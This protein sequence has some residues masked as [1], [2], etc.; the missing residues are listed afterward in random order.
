MR[1]DRLVPQLRHEGSVRVVAYR[2]SMT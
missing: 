2:D 1:L